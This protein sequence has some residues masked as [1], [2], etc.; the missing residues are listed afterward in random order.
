MLVETHR[1]QALFSIAKLIS[2]EF[3]SFD[4][5]RKALV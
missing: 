4:F 1:L 3:M 2:Q 5:G